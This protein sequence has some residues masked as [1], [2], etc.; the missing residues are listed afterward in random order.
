[1]CTSSNH[2]ISRKRNRCGGGSPARVLA[3][4]GCTQVP[5]TIFRASRTVAVGEVRNRSILCDNYRRVRVLA[6]RRCTQ[7]PIRIF[8]ASGTVTVGEVRSAGTR[9]LR[10]PSI[11]CDNYRRVRVLADRGCAQVPITIFRASGPVTAGAVIIPIS[12]I[13]RDFPYFPNASHE[14]N[15][16]LSPYT[17]S[18]RPTAGQN[19]FSRVHG[20]GNAANS[21]EY[22]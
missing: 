15:R 16:F 6:D 10:R 18:I 4:R 13:S 17:P 21:R 3:D 7:V 1:M 20:A 2:D 5:I 9:T 22:G 8:R 19:L 12:V 11:L 14:Q